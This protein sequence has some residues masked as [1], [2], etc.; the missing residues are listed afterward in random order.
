[1]RRQIS[2]SLDHEVIER[3]KAV[4]KDVP[5][6]RWIERAIVNRL[7]EEELEK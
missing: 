1:M 2:V 5:F 7:A 6:S 3:V 4:K